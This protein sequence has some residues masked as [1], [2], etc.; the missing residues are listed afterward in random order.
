MTRLLGFGDCNPFAGIFGRPRTLAWPVD[1]YRVTIP[2]PS[3]GDDGLNPFERV[4][5]GVLH[6]EPGMCIE[7]VSETTCIPTD[8]AR[9]VLFRLRDKGL[10]DGDNRP[11]RQDSMSGPVREAETQYVTAMVFQEVVGGRLLPYIHLLNERSTLKQ[12]ERDDHEVREIRTTR[13]SH[14][15]PP[16]DSK[17]VIAALRQAQQRAAS[18]TES[19]RVPLSSQ[20]R[21]STEPE[22]YLLECPIAIQRS[23]AE[24]RIADPFGN[25][26]SLVL[27]EVLASRL[28]TDEQLQ[29]WMTEWRRSLA[30]ADRETD[31]DARDREPYEA[32]SIRRRYPRLVDSLIPGRRLGVRSTE[33]IY[34][35]LEWALFYCAD[36]RSATVAVEV[37]KQTPAADW[38]DTLTIAAER[39]G[40][41]VPKYG[42]RAVPSGRLKDFLEGKAEM[43]AVTAIAL[44]QAA[45]D[46]EHPLRTVAE[47][48][49]DFLLQ[50]QEIKEVRDGRS[51]GEAAP[52]T[53]GESRFDPL[54]RVCVSLL[55][56]DVR[57][58]DSP[59]VPRGASSLDESRLEA[60]TALIGALGYKLLNHLGAAARDALLEAEQ[61]WLSHV[62]GDDALP[63]IDS[64]NASLQASARQLLSGARTP[65]LSENEYLAEAA[66]RAQAA[67]LGGMP[68]TLAT[69]RAERVREALQG[70]GSTLGACVIGYLLAASAERLERVAAS[71]P[72][73]LQDISDVLARRGHGNQ[74]IP[75]TKSEAGRL[76]KATLRSIR[77]LLEA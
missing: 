12:K 66:A 19:F 14:R 42:F 71:Q 68:P 9:S 21:V 41:D 10:I 11:P 69:V 47:T 23:D 44:M 1:A 72:S 28:D 63:M 15:L 13:E 36:A 25:G 77:T 53:T 34:A 43:A 33:K 38:S 60:R 2:A 46:T 62:D 39:I 35:S 52:A 20:I 16:P 67:G 59:P 50:V 31:S 37:L 32:S 51:H 6:A 8:L 24:Y 18:N 73:L 74:A 70:N 7:A 29:K 58:G 4:V 61:H 40:L 5:L 64:F 17:S 30:K 65:G 26:Y 55:L 54:L 56:P 3:S 22:R 27:E 75:M 57:F 45:N 49:P 76:R 48:Y